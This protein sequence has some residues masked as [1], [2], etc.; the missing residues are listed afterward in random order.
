MQLCR[1]VTAGRARC[2][3]YTPE[4][5]LP[6]DDLASAAG[7]KF[8]AEALHTGDL[9]RLLPTD[10]PAWRALGDIVADAFANPYAPSNFGLPRSEVHLLPP[11]AQP[12]K[13][14]M[15]AGN[16]AAHIE[17]QGGIAKQRQQTFPYVFMKPASTT[18]VGDGAQVH[19]P[20]C[21]PDK[22]DHEVELAVIIGRHARNVTAGQALDFV[23]GYTIINDLSDRGFHPNPQRETRPKDGFFDWLHGK[24]HDGFCPCGPCL[25]TTDEISD[26]QQLALELQVDGEVRQQGTTAEQ[27]FSVAEVI[28]FLSQWMTL[29][30]G[31]IISTGTP[32]GVG[33]AS[34]RFLKAGNQLVA[35]IQG[36]G[37]LQ[38]TMIA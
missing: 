6:L 18:L 35:S 24:W 8:L 5:I 3:V 4:H 7:E 33:N 17:E 21:S 37:Q 31:D 28:A 25:V 26:P 27:I 16:Y 22:I 20:A 12:R 13:L 38:T 36:L 32:A 10:S 9:E 14:L 34:G 2:G 15:L 30:P 29:E 23:A 11:I 1:F 19:I